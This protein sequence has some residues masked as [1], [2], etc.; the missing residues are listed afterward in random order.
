MKHRFFFLILVVFAYSICDARKR[1]PVTTNGENL[2]ALTK[3]T[4]SSEPC[5]TPFGGDNGK[6]L[7]FAI[8]ENKKFFNIYKKDNPFSGSVVQKTV[9]K[10]YNFYPAYNATIDKIAFHC[11]IEGANTSDIYMTNGTQGK[12][13]SQVTESA[14]ANENHPCFSKDGIFIVYDKVSTSEIR[15]DNADKIPSKHPKYVANSDVWMKNLQTGESVLLGNGYQPTFSPDGTK[16]AFVRYSPDAKSCTIWMMNTDGSNQ[17]QVTDA[18]KGYAL[19]P[20]FSPDGKQIV[21]DSWRKETK[22]TDIYIIDVEGNT[23][24][25]ITSN[26]SYDGRPYWTEDGYIY[27]ESDRGDVA[28]N[29][30]IWRFKF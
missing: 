25:Q 17:I 15:R 16:I 14:N 7:F 10:N 6:D 8:R 21:F 1:H 18:K 9:G 13:L 19:H 29:R 27:F 5:I 3:V 11:A 24:H 20:R 22:N 28:G 30:Q 12:A 4:D 2:S 26:E 23:L